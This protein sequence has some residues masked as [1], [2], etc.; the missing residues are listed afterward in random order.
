MDSKGEEEK[1]VMV[2]VRKV[3]ENCTAGDWKSHGLEEC[4]FARREKPISKMYQTQGQ[5]HL[6][7]YGTSGA[8]RRQ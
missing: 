2:Q 8:T 5:V 1:M 3:A 6:P 4:Y 7:R